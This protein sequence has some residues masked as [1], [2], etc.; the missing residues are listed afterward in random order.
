VGGDTSR[1]G[2]VARIV[3]GLAAARLARRYDNI[4]AKAAQQPGRRNT[5]RPVQFADQAGRKE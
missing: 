1:L 4:D 5:R 2:I 3:R